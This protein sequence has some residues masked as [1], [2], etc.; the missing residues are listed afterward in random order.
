MK[1]LLL[2]LTVTSLVSTS[3][4]SY[5]M[6]N[7]FEREGIYDET[8]KIEKLVGENE[9]IIIPMHHIGTENFYKNVRK[10][11][12]SLTN[13]KYKIFYEM[14]LTNNMKSN[15]SSIQEIMDTTMILKFRKAFGLI[16]LSAKGTT[17]YIEFFKEKG[18]K[19]KKNLVP[20][21]NLTDLGLKN[22]LSENVDAT[23]D[24][25]IRAYENKYG[26]II[27]EEYDLKTKLFDNYDRNKCKNKIDKQMFNEFITHYRNGV[28]IN[29]INQNKNAKIAIVYGKNHFVGIKDSLQKLGYKISL[30]Q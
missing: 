5:L 1:K 28:I 18:I 22:K 9:I 3:C 2:F 12:D 15:D 21:S 19:I 23:M 7:F 10:K 6:N 25:L 17:N 26:N 20:Q 4:K 29:K 13:L 8:S 11:V 16:G 27:L 14:I 30:Q 24:E